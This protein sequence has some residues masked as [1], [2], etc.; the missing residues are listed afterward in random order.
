MTPTS[1]ISNSTSSLLSSIDPSVLQGL[2]QAV[3]NAAASALNMQPDE[4]QSQLQSGQSLGQIAQA[5]NV[6]GSTVD[7][8]V[9]AALDAQIQQDIQNGQLTNSQGQTLLNGLTARFAQN[10]GQA[11]G[12]GG[13]HHHHHGGQAAGTESEQGGQSGSLTINI[14]IFSYSPQG[15]VLS[16]NQDGSSGQQV[17]T[18][19]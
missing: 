9:T 2:Q 4:L 3:V 1:G 18:A 13:H 5:Q 16:S 7:Q 10:S 14:D 19:A 15:D 17:N 11:Q 8:D 12:V 6:N